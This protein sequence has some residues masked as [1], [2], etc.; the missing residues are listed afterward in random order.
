MKNRFLKICVLC[1]SGIFGGPVHAQISVTSDVK[2]SVFTVEKMLQVDAK[3]SEQK[4]LDDAIKA[5]IIEEKR[6]P[7]AAAAK[8]VPVWSVR[9]IFGSGGL[10]MA[11]MSVDGSMHFSVSPG[12]R[13]GRCTITAIADRCVLLDPPKNKKGKDI[14]GVCPARACWTGEELTAELQGRVAATI[15]LPAPPAIAPA[16]V[17]VPAGSVG[18]PAPL[19]ARR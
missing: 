10:L 5:G 7:A 4:F 18:L 9:S 14:K 16:P 15:P 12:S 6:V 11:D 17:P 3:Q 13:I 19:P 1:V 8:P 2:S